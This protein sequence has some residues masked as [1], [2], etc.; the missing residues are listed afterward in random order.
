M[1]RVNLNG[2]D[3]T[4]KEGITILD[5]AKENNIHI[6]TLCYHKDLSPNG[7]CRICVV[8]VEGQRTLVA[9]CHTPI[10][11]GMKIKTDSGKVINARKT[12][13]K[14][15]LSSHPDNCHVCDCAN[16]CELRKIFAEYN[17]GKSEFSGA[18]RFYEIEDLNPYMVRDLSKCILCRRCIKACSEIKKENVFA[19]GYRGHNEKIIVNCDENL[20][21]DVCRDCD[22]C[23]KY[24]PVGA[25]IKKEKRF[26][27]KSIEALIIR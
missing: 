18:K 1:M 19:I 3:I 12:I 22:I 21:S 23:V 16:L 11:D 8:E 20:N 9:S 5:L 25:L 6:P 13:L 7:V 2:Y 15:L 4:A 10:V 14:L 24:C 27:K 26:K 17:V